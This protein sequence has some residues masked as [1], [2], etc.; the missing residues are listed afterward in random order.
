MWIDM[1]PDNVVPNASFSTKY[2][3]MIKQKYE[4]EL[5]HDKKMKFLSLRTKLTHNGSFH[6]QLTHNCLF[7]PNSFSE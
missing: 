1:V 3:H 5:M 6:L 2:K 7:H 4:Y